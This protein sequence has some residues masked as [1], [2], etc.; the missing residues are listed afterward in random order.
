MHSKTG[1]R[2]W[3]AR[4]SL[5]D[6]FHAFPKGNV[7]L[8]L[9]CGFFW[10]RVIPC[11]IFIQFSVNCDIIISGFPFPWTYRTGIAPLEI[12]LF[13]RVRREVMV[14]FNH[15]GIVTFRYGYTLVNCFYYSYLQWLCAY[16]TKAKR[17]ESI[18]NAWF[19]SKFLYWINLSIP[20]LVCNLVGRYDLCSEENPLEGIRSGW[21]VA[22][23]IRLAYRLFK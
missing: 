12:N 1:L 23:P 2:K 17:R 14:S 11:Q 10:F 3:S 5:G 9:F 19:Y 18:R 20:I 6:N 21:D 16:G 7:V 4:K 22:Q 8:N 13:D 15:D